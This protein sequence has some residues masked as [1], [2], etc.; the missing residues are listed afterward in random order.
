V[1]KDLLGLGGRCVLT[2]A[3]EEP[4]IASAIYRGLKLLRYEPNINRVVAIESFQPIRGNSTQP[5]G[6]IFYSNF[7]TGN[8][9]GAP[10]TLVPETVAN[11]RAVTAGELKHLSNTRIYDSNGQNSL[12]I[13][14]HRRSWRDTRGTE[15]FEDLRM[16]LQQEIFVIGIGACVVL[17]VCGKYRNYA[18]QRS[19]WKLRF[20]QPE[21]KRMHGRIAPDAKRNGEQ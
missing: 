19:E 20:R 7:P 10:E 4:E 8:S 6:Y 14:E 17:C 21:N 9:G 2:E 5:Y 13:I 3:A 12:L 1:S 15:P 18:I 16:P 11:D